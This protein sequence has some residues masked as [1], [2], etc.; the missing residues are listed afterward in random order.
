M[1][2]FEARVES[3]ITLGLSG[4]AAGPTQTDLSQFLV[5]GAREVLTALPRKK[6]AL[7]T[8]S[9][10]L[11]STTV[12]FTV[13]NSDVFDVTRDDG[14]INQPCRKI[15][16]EMSGRASD[17]SDMSAASATDPVYY[18]QGNLLAVI[19]EPTNSNN[20]HVRDI[21]FPAIVY[22][23]SSISRFPEEGVYLVVLYG[24]IK[25]LQNALSFLAKSS[26]DITGAFTSC[27][28]EIDKIVS[29]VSVPAPPA[30]NIVTYT[31]ATN[32]D[33]SVTGVST[34][35]ATAPTI[36]DV[37][38]HAPTFTKPVVSPDFNQVNT[39]L[40]TNEDVELASVKIQELQTQISEYNSNIQNE[41]AE[42]NKE[43]VKYQ[44]EFQE[45]VTKSNAD[46]Q[47]AIA[48][49]N[50]EA[51]EKRQEAQQSTDM[52]KFNKAQDQALAL[53]NAAKQME[54]LIADNNSKLQKYSNELQSYQAQVNKLS[55]TAQSYLNEAKSRLDYT[56]FRYGLFEK[57]Q[58]KLQAD[59]DKGI[60][61]LKS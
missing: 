52:D 28:T 20:A 2:T 5:D 13:T 3:L 30:I 16:P 34:A 1:A 41:Q 35:T 15:P 23:D 14:T 45:A 4:G 59:Y 33:A 54:D 56:G 47:V 26:S 44:M 42:F 55:Q 27:N 8:R 21:D 36:I 19:P 12:N 50:H 24:A 31:D 53:T 49:A 40:D 29:D 10:T 37:S 7:Y 48:N 22:S 6:Q 57:Q 38:S 25:C 58:A 43:N 39:H 11:N 51:Q 46:L 9:S 61:L 17:S 18:I 32:S 60:S